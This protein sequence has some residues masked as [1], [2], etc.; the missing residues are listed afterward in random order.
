MGW[1]EKTTFTAEC[2]GINCKETAIVDRTK[3]VPKQWKFLTLGDDF[4]EECHD[5]F[6]PTHGAL[7]CADC[8]GHLR[9]DIRLIKND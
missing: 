6:V 2:D 1:S 9:G 5:R 3:E 7:I 8:Y 4:V